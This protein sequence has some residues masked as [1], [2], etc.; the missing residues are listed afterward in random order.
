M[1]KLLKSFF[2]IVLVLAIIFI[3]ILSVEFEATMAANKVHVIHIQKQEKQLVQEDVFDE[4][5]DENLEK[6]PLFIQAKEALKNRDY[7]KTESL[8]LKLLVDYPSAQL[9]NRL[10]V[11]YYKQKYFSRALKAYNNA[12]KSDK[13]YYRAYFN[14]ALWYSAKKQYEKAKYNY[15]Q[16]IFYHPYHFKSYFNLAALFVK[17]GK[18]EEAKQLYI[19][20]L[21]LSNGP[22]KAK[23]YYRLAKLEAKENL[24]KAE[25]YIRQSIRLEPSAVRA[26]LF[27]ALLGV[28]E[29]R[30]EATLIKLIELHPGDKAPLTALVKIYKKSK[31]YRKALKL[32]ENYLLTFPEDKEALWGVANLWI[33]L[34]KYKE[35]I[36]YLEAILRFEPSNEEVLDRLVYAYM[37]NKDY[38]KAIRLSQEVLKINS[39]NIKMLHRLAEIYKQQDDLRSYMKVLTKIVDL[40]PQDSDAL[41]QLALAY[42]EQKNGIKAHLLIDKALEMKKDASLW[43]IKGK[44][45]SQLRQR[46]QA[47]LMYEK[48][49]A[50]EPLNAKY[51]VAAVKVSMNMKAL[52]KALL[53]ALRA[54]K[55]VPKSWENA[56]L[57]S[58][59]YYRQK[60]YEKAEEYIERVANIE[61][62]DIKVL[63]QKAK[64]Y[65][66]TRRNELASGVYEKLVEQE[67]S[68]IK[69]RY[70]Y[71]KSLKKS[72]QY[73][74]AL[75][76]VEKVL[77][78]KSDHQ[79]AL[80]LK[81]KIIQKLKE[82]K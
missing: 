72:M 6:N 19:K 80:K 25:A 47:L 17:Q 24:K 39:K 70:A 59:I 41:G 21:S 22:N 34:S 4:E 76:E 45:Y 38:Q 55:I 65:A 74:K 36:S 12:I 10:G 16:A 73:E 62:N 20:A 44:I 33:H 28:D 71:A 81:T 67:P 54:E 82:I 52:D 35:A 56:L 11:L 57:L 48:S 15:Q 2:P 58:K 43:Y 7:V 26:H 78:L 51:L 50:L 23:V 53:Y 75:K 77:Q 1:R 40:F 42:L 61:K 37:K 69:L 68:N 66:K 64:I 79:N 60:N 27:L 29:K 18:V 9:Y 46:E 30:K 14:R 3:V 8:Y 13:R 32:Y 49:I 31:S 63:E 5:I